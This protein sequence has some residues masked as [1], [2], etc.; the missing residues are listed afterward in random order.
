MNFIDI[1]KAND[2]ILLEFAEKYGM[3]IPY[4]QHHPNVV[5]YHWNLFQY[6][7]WRTAQAKE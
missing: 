5:K 6:E 2:E 4:I 7:K 3:K 1:S